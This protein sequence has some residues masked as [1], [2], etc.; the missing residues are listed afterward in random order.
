[1]PIDDEWDEITAKRDY[2]V[3]R[4]EHD[5]LKSKD[6]ISRYNHKKSIGD[7]DESRAQ[8]ELLVSQAGEP[9]RQRKISM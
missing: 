1:M 7:D 5:R 8:R 6:V 9:F 4:M 3:G 2:G